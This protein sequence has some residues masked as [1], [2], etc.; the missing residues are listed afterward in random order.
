MDPLVSTKRDTACA[1]FTLLLSRIEDEIVRGGDPAPSM[2]TLSRRDVWTGFSLDDRLRWARIAQMAGEMET[3]LEVL[4]HVN[5]EDPG[6]REAWIQ[7]LDLLAVL[8]RKEDLARVLA[9]AG[10]HLPGETPDRWLRPDGADAGRDPDLEAAAAPF[11]R[12]R[13]REELI[14]RYL[15]LFAGREDCF[16]RQWA[17]KAEGKQG[18]VPVRRAMEPADVEEHLKGRKTYGIYLLRSDATVTAAVIDADL[19]KRFRAGRWTGEE[20]ALVRRERDYLITRIREISGEAGLRPLLEFSGGKGYHFWYFFE[21]PLKAGDA[22]ACLE[23]VTGPIA[24]DFSAFNLE[25][26]PKQAELTGKGMG[27]LV[28]LP[29]GVHRVTGKRS[30]F[31]ECADRSTEAQ[32]E[33]LAK[34]VKGGP[35]DA[36]LIRRT[37]AK[38]KLVLHPRHRRWAAEFPELHGLETLCPPLGQIIAGCRQG[39]DITAR[40]EKVLYQ[41]VG[42][43]PRARSL[44]HGLMGA[45][46]E[47]NPHL[48]DFRLSRLRG[49]PLGCRRIHSL[50]G[51]TGDACSFEN[52]GDYAHPLL[53]LEA[54]KGV[55]EGRSKKVCDL[56]SAMENLKTALKQVERYIS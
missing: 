32:L 16:A 35:D 8:D 39:R 56:Q 45:V 33:F 1:D 15:D 44:M 36:L 34:V 27:N 51:F 24:K 49:T 50:L 37:E 40:E 55:E 41:T 30:R 4:D 11:D 5:R 47:Y 14:S 29:L 52:Q 53:H 43:L 21:A 23:S 12:L 48:V 22:K 28:K 25:V 10:P 13:H 38:K 46:P 54:W 42:F 19:S 17:D 18:Y 2:R 31:L 20:K 3:A 26:F 7:R 9:L 6:C